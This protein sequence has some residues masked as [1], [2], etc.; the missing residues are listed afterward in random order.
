ML[1]LPPTWAEDGSLQIGVPRRGAGSAAEEN[2]QD[3]GKQA[4]LSPPAPNL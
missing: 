4:I 3:W 2:Y 1:A